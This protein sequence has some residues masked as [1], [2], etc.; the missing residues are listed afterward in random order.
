MLRR[1]YLKKNSDVIGFENFELEKTPAP[2]INLHQIRCL[3]TT[4]WDY[5]ANNNMKHWNMEE[6]P[7]T[8]AKEK[9]GRQLKE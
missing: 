3:Q 4:D 1:H 5:L 7:I 2:I 9:Y 8:C 6:D